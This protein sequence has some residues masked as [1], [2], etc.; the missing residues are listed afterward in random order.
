[1]A[2]TT[3]EATIDSYMAAQQS[4]VNFGN[5]TALVY[6]VT[7]IGGTKQGQR[8]SIFNF[9]VS[10]LSGHT[11]NSAKLSRDLTAIVGTDVGGRITRCTRPS[12]WVEL[13]VT[14]AVYSTGNNWTNP[15]GDFDDV[16]PGKVDYTEPNATGVHELTGLL[17]YVTDALDNRSGIVSLINRLQNELPAATEEIDYKS[18]EHADGGPLLIVDHTPPP[19]GPSQSMRGWWA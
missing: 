6:A 5:S 1:V 10:S 8:R 13:E 19:A 7:I 16:T 3:F 18:T 2:E 12:T 14:W 15:G 9:D 17:A 4:N 11:I